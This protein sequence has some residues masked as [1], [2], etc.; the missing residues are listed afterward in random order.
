MSRAEVLQLLGRSDEAR[1]AVD[2]AVS[3]AQRKSGTAG[4]ADA[5]AL[6]DRLG[7]PRVSAG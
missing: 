4:V 1:P 5:G 3:V 7:A 6:L 2:A